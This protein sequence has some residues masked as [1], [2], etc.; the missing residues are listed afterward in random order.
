MAHFT[1]I[2]QLKFLRTALYN[3]RQRY[4]VNVDFYRLTESNT[5]FTS[6]LKTT[7]RTKYSVKKLIRLPIKTI[8]HS[9]GDFNDF[10]H[11]ITTDHNQRQFILDM[12]MSNGYIPDE[13]DYLVIGNDRYEIKSIQILD[14]DLGFMISAESTEGAKLKRVFTE[15]ITLT[16]E[17]TQTIRAP[18]QFP[19]ATFG[20]VLNQGLM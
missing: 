16:L 14:F 1:M 6:G 12:R 2:K 17:P 15:S 9:L 10:A 4:G 11:F 18:T 5:D 7:T 8:R 13:N 3:L 20:I 19:K